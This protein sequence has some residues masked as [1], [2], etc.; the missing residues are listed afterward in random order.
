MNEQVARK[1]KPQLADYNQQIPAPSLN[2]TLDSSLTIKLKIQSIMWIFGGIASFT[3]AV[4]LSKVLSPNIPTLVILFMRS[5]FG[6]FFITPL[7]FKEGLSSL[8][9]ARPLLNGLRVIFTCVALFCTY[10]AY[11]NLPLPIAS[12]LGF[13]EPLFLLLLSWALLG[14]HINLV[15]WV[16]VICGYLGVLLIAKPGI[17]PIDNAMYVAL[18]A[19]LLASLSVICLKKLSNTESNSTLLFY[20][21]FV[22]FIISS[23]LAAFVWETPELTEIFILLLIGFFGI[24]YQFCYI[25]AVRL[26]SVSFLAPFQYIRLIMAIGI[27][28]IFFN[29]IPDLWVF[30]GA[31]IIILS[32][33]VVGRMS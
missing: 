7:L 3:T 27:G 5:A 17:S 4:S 30:M 16:S 10:Y 20:T 26:S 11:R 32:T 2:E 6:L 12:T 8:K 33:Y 14:E 9:T 25:R 18:F 1:L 29:E 21:N 24:S 31:G 19:N 23:V 28:L 15:K 22:T 13:T